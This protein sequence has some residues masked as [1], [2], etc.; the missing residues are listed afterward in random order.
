MIC[1]KIN[2][3]RR[4]NFEKEEVLKEEKKNGR[5]RIIS[6]NERKILRKCFDMTQGIK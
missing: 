4:T 6:I 2:F 3:R 1:M 5:K